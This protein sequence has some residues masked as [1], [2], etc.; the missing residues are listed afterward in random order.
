MSDYF[1]DVSVRETQGSMFNPSFGGNLT[2][3]QKVRLQAAAARGKS[4]LHFSDI[5]KLGLNPK[6]K[7]STPAGIYGYLLDKKSMRC[8]LGWS[9]ATKRNHHNWER[10]DPDAPVGDLKEPPRDPTWIGANECGIDSF[11]TDRKFVHA[12]EL[13]NYKKEGLF[14][15][16]VRRDGS[17]K[18]SDRDLK[19][20]LSQ[21]TNW[22]VSGKGKAH[23]TRKKLTDLIPVATR[24]GRRGQ[25]DIEAYEAHAMRTLSFRK[26]LAA[27]FAEEG[28]K[29]RF[30]SPF[31]KL[32][33]IT[34]YVARDPKKWGILLRGLGI[35]AVIDEGAGLIHRSEPRQMVIFRGDLIKRLY[36]GPNPMHYYEAHSKRD[37]AAKDKVRFKKARIEDKKALGAIKDLHSL[38]VSDKRFSDLWGKPISTSHGFLLRITL[39]YITIRVRFVSSTG[40]LVKGNSKSAHKNKRIIGYVVVDSASNAARLPKFPLTLRNAG[41]VYKEVSAFVSALISK[42]KDLA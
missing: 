19:T 5:N 3:K 7:F 1:T 11:A 17:S 12:G 15:V 29:S 31:G 24:R 27:K 2:P 26:A 8:L 39:N 20:A 33:N 37:K 34:R 38:F 36:T 10:L 30:K 22:I 23:L 14:T 21:L 18:F 4:I 42:H 32:W 6:T 41:K 25:D 13:R 9:K 40:P 16:V 35:V 28:E